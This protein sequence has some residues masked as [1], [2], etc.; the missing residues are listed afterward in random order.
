MRSWRTGIAGRA[1]ATPS[2]K[3]DGLTMFRKSD[4]PSYQPLDEPAFGLW[5]M[6]DPLVL[7]RGAAAISTLRKAAQKN[8]MGLGHDFSKDPPILAYLESPAA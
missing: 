4:R 7:R 2:P 3:P 5:L 1:A 6:P 8:V